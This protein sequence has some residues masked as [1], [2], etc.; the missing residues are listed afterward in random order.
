MTKVCPHCT[1]EQS[2]KDFGYRP[3]GRLA[4]WCRS[5]DRVR[6]KAYRK[7]RN[8][9]EERERSWKRRGIIRPDGKPLLREDFVQ[10]LEKQARKCAICY[11]LESSF[12][13]GLAVDHNHKTGRIRGLLCFKC[14]KGIGHFD[15][16]ISQFTRIISYIAE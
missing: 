5:C 13:R 10:L 14:N 7:Q 6:Q 2:Y 4:S 16:D 11:K 8:P 3:D 12:Q 9:W 1:R 15:E